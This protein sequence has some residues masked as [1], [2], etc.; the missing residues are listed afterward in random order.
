M[1]DHQPHIQK[2]AD[3][4]KKQT[5][6]DVTEGFDVFFHLVLVFRLGNQHAGDKSPQSQRQT[7][8][9]GNPGRTQ[10]NQQQ[11]QHEQFLRPTFDDDAEP[12]AD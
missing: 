12:A 1:L 3:R 5:E 11:V 9:F 10:R 4:N 8:H 2:H 7:G 6:Q